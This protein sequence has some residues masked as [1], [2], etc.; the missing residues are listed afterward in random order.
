MV[1]LD[2]DQTPT[3]SY[4]ADCSDPDPVINVYLPHLPVSPSAITPEGGE[5]RPHAQIEVT[6]ASNTNNNKENVF[7]A[8][9]NSNQMLAVPPYGTTQPL[10][11]MKTQAGR[12]PALSLP[13][14]EPTTYVSS[15][16]TFAPQNLNIGN[17]SQQ[18]P[19]AWRDGVSVP[20]P[21][22]SPY[23]Q[24]EVWGHSAT[25]TEYARSPMPE[26]DMNHQQQPSSSS[27]LHPHPHAHHQAQAHH[28]IH[29]QQSM[30][31]QSN[32][33]ATH[34]APILT[35]AS[36]NGTP[37]PGIDSPAF[38]GQST[39]TTAQ[40]GYFPRTHSGHTG[41]SYMQQQQMD[42]LQQHQHHQQQATYDYG[43]PYL[44]DW[45]QT[46]TTA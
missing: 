32:K 38:T 35:T 19:N 41:H 11:R 26:L 37:S 7:Q 15:P 5:K 34:L 22:L 13:T 44:A 36:M 6:A 10:K 31:Q 2:L 20:P 17:S 3:T 4:R 8:N 30:Q 33:Y 46:Y 24:Q 18:Q 28:Q 25:P 9:P 16:F 42:Y 1:S 39:A 12:L 23:P 21:H 14:Y 43:S 40:S 29:A 45:D 27:G